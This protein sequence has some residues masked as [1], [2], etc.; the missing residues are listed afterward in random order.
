MKFGGDSLAEYR[1]RDIKEALLRKSPSSS[2][3]EDQ[4]LYGFLARMPTTYHF[5]ATMFT[6][7]RDPSSAP[8]MWGKSKIIL[9]HKDKDSDKSDPTQFRMISLTSNVGKL[10][11]SLESLGSLSLVSGKPTNIAFYLS[12]QTRV[13]EVARE[14]GWHPPK[15]LDSDENF[16]PEHTL[17]CRELRFVAIY[18]LFFGDLWA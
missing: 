15:S 7:F 1:P 18:A 5:L 8:P 11:H 16:K 12:T 13:A 9:L 4:L 14:H 2:P 3:G 6:K 10:Y 17:F